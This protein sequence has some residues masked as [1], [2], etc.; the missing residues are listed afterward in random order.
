MAMPYINPLLHKQRFALKHCHMIQGNRFSGSSPGETEIIQPDI[1][2]PFSPEHSVF[3][4]Q[5]TAFQIFLDFAWLHLE[6]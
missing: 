3:R 6:K 1:M 4:M 5:S 2:R